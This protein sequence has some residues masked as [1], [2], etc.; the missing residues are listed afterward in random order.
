MSNK[1]L[2]VLAN[3]I[4]SILNEDIDLKQMIEKVIALIRTETGYSAVG[5]R[6]R[7]GNDFP[8]F[9]QKGFS[10]HFI[11]TENSIIA[12]DTH[13]NSCGDACDAPA[14]ECTCGLV[15]DGVKD[16]GNP[17][18]T[19]FGSFYTNNSFPILDIP[20]DE[21]PRF[22]PRNTCIHLGYRSIAIIPIRCH[23][24]TI[25]TLQINDKEIDAFSPENIRFLE[26]ISLSLGMALMRKQSEELVREERD[27]LLEIK[28]I[29]RIGS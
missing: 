22:Q 23:G 1:E 17:L 10:P 9:V 21:D 6:L 7:D 27:K 12:R 28:S 24:A 19:E 14:L 29:A 16:S 8:Y 25:G 2:P 13:C 11:N 18:F 3:S 5:M 20:I 4:L 15:I 26:N